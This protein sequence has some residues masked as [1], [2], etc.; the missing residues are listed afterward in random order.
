MPRGITDTFVLYIIII[1]F[2][3]NYSSE[4]VSCAT[5][6]ENKKLEYNFHL[7]GKLH[8]KSFPFT[9]KCGLVATPSLPLKKKQKKTRAL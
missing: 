8:H 1:I 3:F 5:R 4:G 7:K 9:L 2:Y 6:T